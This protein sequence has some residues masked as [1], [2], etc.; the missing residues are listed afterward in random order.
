MVALLVLLAAGC[1]TDAQG[2]DACRRIEQARCRRAASCPELGLASDQIQAC[3]E[4][5]RDQCL[6]GL[7]VPDPGPVVV[8]RCVRA[9]EQSSTACELVVAPETIPEC[10]FLLPPPALPEDAGTGADAAPAGD[11]ASLDAE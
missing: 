5:S 2:S 1:G 6:H 10:V 3:V 7:M 11:A 4:Y 9:I 8:D